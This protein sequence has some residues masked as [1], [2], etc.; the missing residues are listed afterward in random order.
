M[1]PL[2][3][4]DPGNPDVRSATRYLLWLAARTWPSLLAAIGFATL[5]MVSQALIPATVG[6]AIDAGL[7]ARDP[8]G[9]LRWG[10]VLFGLGLV[11]GASGILR[12]RMAAFNYLSAIYRTVQLTVQQANRIG[13]TLPKR[14]STGEVVSIGTSDINHIGGALDITARG[15]GS[16]VAVITVGVILLT[17]SVPLGLVVVVGVP[18]M[19]LIAG[20]LIKPLQRRQQVYRDQ[21]GK[22]TTRAGDL[23]AGLRVLRGVGGEST[24]AGRYRAESQDL[25]SA[26][27]RVARIEALLAAAEILLPG[28]FLVLVTWLGARFALRGEISA[29]ELVALY[30]YAAFLVSPLRQ[31]TEA[32]DR[33]TRGHVAARRVVRMFTL[34]PEFTSPAAPVT[35]PRGPLV[36]AESG[37]TVQPGRLTAIAAREPADAAA[38]ADRLGRF[39]DGP[40][41][42]SGVPLADLD[43]AEVRQRILL[44]DNDARLFAGPLRDELDPVGKGDRHV[45]DALDAASAADVV[46]A[47]PDGLDALVAERG[48]EFS[49]GQ[50]QRLRLARALVADPEALVLVEPTSA[51]DAH[52]E[53]RIAARL[54]AAR[55]GRTTV[56]CTT[57]PL[58][59][60]QADEVAFVADG[61]VV[62]AGTHRDLLR[63]RPDY[64]AAVTREEDE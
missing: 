2:P 3:V 39:A 20:A 55:A 18:V 64:A 33:L 58:V 48:R 59:L 12:H 36:D 57:S 10:A 13:A 28:M 45:A 44:A 24:F 54:G 6:R 9:L 56:V 30:G 62:A 46:D 22:L 32:I 34:V 41:T 60:D 50:Q 25:R 21:E 51:V 15:T 38:I 16:L 42:L 26:G 14:L 27:V 40:V 29:G 35:A 49:G 5:W 52:T 19:M 11:T 37:L 23:V 63:R 1:R 17:T 47:L 61:R 4:G 43:L 53:A 7:S 31:L 8:D